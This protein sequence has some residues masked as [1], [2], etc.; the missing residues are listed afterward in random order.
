[1]RPESLVMTPSSSFF[2]ASHLSPSSV[3]PA[4]AETRKSRARSSGRND[5][6]IMAAVLYSFVFISWSHHLHAA[7][8][9]DKW[10]S[11]MTFDRY[12]L[13]NVLRLDMLKMQ[14]WNHARRSNMAQYLATCR[15]VKEL[16]PTCWRREDA[17]M[18]RLMPAPHIVSIILSYQHQTTLEDTLP[19]TI[20][21]CKV[22]IV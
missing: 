21:T 20:S 18:M 5:K 13:P 9:S 12:Q 4:R 15:I 1:M 10:L 6:D 3:V 2:W 17:T 14:L 11:W 22:L 7:R 8:R 19:P 16:L